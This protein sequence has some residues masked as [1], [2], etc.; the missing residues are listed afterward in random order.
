[1]MIELVA[2]FLAVSLI[3]YVILGGADFG[4]GIL[5]LTGG[6]QF[7]RKHRKL[8]NQAMGPVWEANHVWLILALVILFMGFPTIFRQI[9]ITY[10]IPLTLLLLGITIRG[11]AFTF[12]HYDAVKDRSQKVYSF[13]FV[14]SSLIAPL[15]LGMIAG[16]IP[17]GL[18]ETNV[19]AGWRAVF[20]DPWLNWYAVSV[21]IFM[22]CLCGY[23]AA[24]YLAGEARRNERGD[25]TRLATRYAVLAVASGLGVFALS[26]YYEM[27][28]VERFIAS[29]LALASLLGATALFFPLREFL[30][31]HRIWVS[32]ISVSAQIA[33]VILGWFAINFPTV[34]A[35]KQGSLDIYTYAAG[36]E[37]LYQLLL[38]LL[39]GSLLIFP[40]LAYLLIVFKNQKV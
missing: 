1:M 25:F 12:R 21:G 38:A 35:T 20:V 10:H 14:V 28:L 22:I 37:T 26:F 4:A 40:A 29:P 8:I 15:F 9:S 7:R 34:L 11:C 16:S 32:R 2:F 23:I 17:A 30:Q 31:A 18:A 5:E 13:L 3:L 39:V 33:A 6:R 19:H 36:P 27:G 24:V